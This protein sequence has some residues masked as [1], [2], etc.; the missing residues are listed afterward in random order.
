[1]TSSIE[2]LKRINF[3]IKKGNDVLKTTYIDYGTYVDGGLAGGYRSA[4]LSFISSLFGESHPYFSQLSEMKGNQKYVTD[5][6]IAIL[7]SIKEEVKNG[8][9]F[10]YRQLITAEV[11]SDFLEMG[12]YLLDEKY[13]DAAAVMIG[14]VLEE[15]I[16]QL[17]GTYSIDITITNSRGDI[18]P[19]KADL[20]NSDLVKASVYNALQQKQVTAWLGLRN[21]AAHGKYSDYTIEEIK[22]MYQGVLNFVTQ[23]S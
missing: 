23:V 8:W 6:A 13:K 19:K 15:H 9:L 21:S 7:K 12:K 17:C 10:S 14:S 1:M 5:T 2:L 4:V 11:F 18:M 22:L 3:L 20:M 16:R